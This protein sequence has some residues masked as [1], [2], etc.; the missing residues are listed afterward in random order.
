MA[1]SGFGAIFQLSAV[2]IVGAAGALA[3]LTKVPLPKTELE[4][5][6]STHHGSVGGQREDI[7][8]LINLP[9]MTLEMNLIAGSTTDTTCQ[10]AV[11]SKALY[12]F[13][14]TVPAA[15]SATWTYSGQCYV[16]GYD[17]GDAEVDGKMSASLDIKPQGAVTR[18]AGP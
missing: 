7:P 5:E 14:I 12:Y 9:P 10:T 3:E 16:T 15:G 13:K 6:D 8:L 11:L 2:V 4:L 18:V 1:K 17:P